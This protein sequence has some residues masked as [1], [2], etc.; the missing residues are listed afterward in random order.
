MMAGPSFANLFA[1]SA[2][3]EAG[4][5]GLFKMP[6]KGGARHAESISGFRKSL[7]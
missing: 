6:V 4:S 3:F 2:K 1:K 7:F 5:V